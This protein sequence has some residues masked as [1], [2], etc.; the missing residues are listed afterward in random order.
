MK[1][2]TGSGALRV[3]HEV[4]LSCRVPRVQQGTEPVSV[5]AVCPQGQSGGHEA[6]LRGEQQ[7]QTSSQPGAACCRN[8]HPSKSHLDLRPEVSVL[9][10]GALNTP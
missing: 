5:C 2:R 1:K 3:H 8:Q 6:V 10:S 9:L 4:L 7:L